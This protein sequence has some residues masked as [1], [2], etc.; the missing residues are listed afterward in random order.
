MRSCVSPLICHCHCRLSA[1]VY[2]KGSCRISEL[3]IGGVPDSPINRYTGSIFEYEYLREQRADSFFSD[4]C[5]GS[6]RS[7][8]QNREVHLVAMSL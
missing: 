2:E 5:G 6:V 3:T 7:P 1:Y 8:L 4:Y